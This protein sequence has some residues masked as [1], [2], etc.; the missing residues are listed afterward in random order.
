M[1]NSLGFHANGALNAI[2]G[3]PD[4]DMVI[5]AGREGTLLMTM[6]PNLTRLSTPD[7]ANRAR[8][9]DR[10]HHHQRKHELTRRKSTKPQHELK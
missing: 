7:P 1:A 4:R 9:L 3:S 8:F 10:K 2:S 5:I 6:L